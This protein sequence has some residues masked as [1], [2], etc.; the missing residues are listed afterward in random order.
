MKIFLIA[1]TP[2]GWLLVLEFLDFLELFFDFFCSCK[3]LEKGSSRQNLVEIFLIFFLIVLG[4]FWYTSFLHLCN[5]LNFKPFP[6]FKY[7]TYAVA[8]IFSNQCKQNNIMLY[9]SCHN[10]GWPTIRGGTVRE[11]KEEKNNF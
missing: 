7:I 11:G 10:S 8:N 9:S 4:F 1:A 3:I 6:W 5:C 2:T